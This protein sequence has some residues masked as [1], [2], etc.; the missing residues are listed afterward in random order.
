MCNNGRSIALNSDNAKRRKRR[1]SKGERERERWTEKTKWR[2]I[3]CQN[4]T[5]TIASGS[6][7]EADMWFAT[8]TRNYTIGAD[9]C[10]AP[11]IN[12]PV[13]NYTLSRLHFQRPGLDKRRDVLFKR[14]HSRQLN[15]NYTE[16]SFK[17]AI[18]YILLQFYCISQHGLTEQPLSSCRLRKKGS[19]YRKF[20]IGELW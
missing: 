7:I 15:C 8:R 2:M 20:N 10:V 12:E 5:V 14:R 16:K 4:A 17:D 18:I 13:A 6:T 19:K 11:L 9:L 1:W 3:T